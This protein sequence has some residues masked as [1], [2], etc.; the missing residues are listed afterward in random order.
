VK[1]LQQLLTKEKKQTTETAGNYEA[2][3]PLTPQ[4][5][6]GYPDEV[7]EKLSSL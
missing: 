5:P 3:P 4:K 2:W 1:K 6:V 7:L